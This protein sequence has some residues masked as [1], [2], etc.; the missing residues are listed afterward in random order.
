M[1]FLRKRP[2]DSS[3]AE[4]RRLHRPTRVGN[5]SFVAGSTRPSHGQIGRRSVSPTEI[6]V[7]ACC[8]RT[9]P[10]EGAGMPMFPPSVAIRAIS[11]DGGR[12]RFDC[13]GFAV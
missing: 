7:I 6:T 5:G 11:P 4:T 9:R 8:P 1:V 2:F 10:P 3:I 13:A 12:H